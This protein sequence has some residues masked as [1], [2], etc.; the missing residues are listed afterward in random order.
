MGRTLTY[1]GLSLGSSLSAGPS[2]ARGIPQ[3]PSRASEKQ[4]LAGLNERFYSYVEKVKQLQLENKTLQAQLHHLTGGASVTSSAD[5]SA[6]I[7]VEIQLTD[8]RSTVENLTLENVRYE[9]ELDNIRGT[10]E[11]L[12]AKYEFELGVKFQLET[13]IAAM[14]RDLETASELRAALET[15]YT[16]VLDDLD[17]IKKTQEEELATIQSKL[18]STTDTSS[19]SMIEVDTVRSFDL[20]SALNKLRADY[21]KSVQ[22]NKDDA[23]I[24]FKA[25]MEEIQGETSKNTEVISTVKNEIGVVKK[26]LQNLNTELQSL[27]STNFALE[28]S[29]AEAIARSSV[30]IAEYQSQITSLEAAIDSAKVELHNLILSYQELLDIKQALDVEIS[31]YRKLLEGEDSRFPDVEV[32]S[33]GTYTFSSESGFQKKEDSILSRSFDDIHI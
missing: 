8:L 3:L 24:Y 16:T 13:D 17:F 10:A 14:K 4:T 21:E 28:N 18:G 1:G 29:L 32:L 6:P 27:L 9:I 26:D 20:T 15:K 12:K 5:P 25:K 31:T 2:L 11:E 7:N 22:Q 30:G 19:V 23:E 33:R